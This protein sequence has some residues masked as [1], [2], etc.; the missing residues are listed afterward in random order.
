M[1][2]SRWVALVAAGACLGSADGARAEDVESVPRTVVATIT[3]DEKGDATAHD[4]VRFPA[5]QFDA[6]KA[7]TPDPAPFLRRLRPDR[8]NYVV[9]PSPR[10]AYAEKEPTL[11]LDWTAKGIARDAGDGRWELALDETYVEGDTTKVVDGRPQ[12]VFKVA[13]TLDRSEAYMGSVTWVLPEGAT[14]VQWDAANYRLQWSRTAPAQPGTGKLEAR[15]EAKPRIMASAYKTY[16]KGAGFC[17]TRVGAGGRF[18]L[19]AN[20]APPW[21]ARVVLKNAGTGTLKDVRVRYKL[22]G[23]TTDWSPWEEFPELVAGATAVSV[24]FPVILGTVA[25]LRDDTPTNLLAEWSWDDGA[26]A[27]KTRSANAR[28]AILGINEFVFNDLEAGERF[29][30]FFAQTV[31][32]APLLAA[33]VSR[34]DPV[35][36]QFAALANKNAGGVFAPQDDETALKVVRQCYDLLR[37]NNFTYQAPPGAVEHAT[38]F[39]VK[40][41]QNV[42]FP[43]DVIMARSGTCIDLAILFASMVNAIGLKPYLVVIPGHCFPAVEM[44]R[45]PAG[46]GNV[47][48]VETTMIGGGVRFGSESFRTALHYGMGEFD[49]ALTSGKYVLLPVTSLWDL[50]VNNP[51]L[52]DLPADIFQRWPISETGD[53]KAVKDPFEGTWEGSVSAPGEAAGAVPLAVTIVP[54]ADP[55]DPVDYLAT[56]SATSR[57]TTARGTAQA[58]VV[59]NMTGAARGGVLQLTG[60]EKT[61]TTGEGAQPAEPDSIVVHLVDGHLEGKF[62]SEKAGWAPITL[63]LP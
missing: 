34:N 22:E 15:F 30:D 6:V 5:A 27:P 40:F 53:P 9:G 52:E 8:P 41:V 57:V 44:P 58:S 24:Y 3:L 21:V 46:S 37:L 1:A 50:G 20:L 4:E 61:V 48:G 25:R 13:G 36:K 28:V 60:V 59:E 45:P 16:A 23:Y 43:R 35:V 2:R 19:G 12:A 63:R 18:L 39:D 56:S 7:A 31:N 62:G 29:D 10:G 47:Y 32:N 54:N 51:E 14:D 49:Q 33:W 42:K 38:S 55:L 26:G 11:T 17:A